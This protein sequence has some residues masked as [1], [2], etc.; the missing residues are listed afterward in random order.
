MSLERIPASRSTDPHTSHAA[1]QSMT[2]AAATHRSLIWNA[3]KHAGPM[4]C[5]ELAE[6]TGLD[7]VAIARRLAE[8]VGQGLC[9]RSET[10][11]E[12]TPS[13]RQGSV[14]ETTA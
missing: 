6:V 10:K 5:Y 2:T 14:W 12:T 8:L 7:P 9:R 4:G 11:H 13:G 3:L 1:G